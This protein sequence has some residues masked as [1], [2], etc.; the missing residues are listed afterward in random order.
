ME[1]FHSIWNREIG[2]GTGS[3]GGFGRKGWLLFG[4]HD[5]ID[6]SSNHPSV[7]VFCFLSFSEID[8]RNE[9]H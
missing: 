5:L 9:S 2:P 6:D 8:K 3:M 7:R 4:Q 1:R